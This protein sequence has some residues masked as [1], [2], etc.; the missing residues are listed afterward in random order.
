MHRGTPGR[1]TVVEA[2]SL[3]HSFLGFSLKNHESLK[4]R[5][6]HGKKVRRGQINK[7]CVACHKGPAAGGKKD[8]ATSS[9]SWK[10]AM[11]FTRHQKAA[12]SAC[13]DCHIGGGEEY[14]HKNRDDFFVG[15]HATEKCGKCHTDEDYEKTTRECRECHKNGHGAKIGARC[16]ECHTA[17]AWNP[18]SQGHVKNLKGGH[19]GVR[20][21][22]CH[23]E[24]DF[25]GLSWECVR[26][27]ENK[28][29]AG[30]VDDCLK[31]HNQNRWED[32]TMEHDAAGEDCASCH[33]TPKGHF[34]GTCN[35]CH[36]TVRNWRTGIKHP[37][38]EDHT[39]RQY[40]CSY[41]HPA[42][43]ES[44]DCRRCHKSRYPKDD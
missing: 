26:C 20:C 18:A 17:E 27:H 38:I 11:A 28:H 35:E 13:L 41:C 4:C 22:S 5:D 19:R 2:T 44:V 24:N 12:G 9:S 8:R 37:R 34:P 36:K 31:C 14:K 3:D 6:C 29:T 39:F 1:L 23:K 7:K 25:T 40:P 43:N 32:V 42:L 33:K 21:P 16:E 15:E 10:K 30:A